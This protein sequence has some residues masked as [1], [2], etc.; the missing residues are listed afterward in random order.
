MKGKILLLLFFICSLFSGCERN[1][2]IIEIEEEVEI[3][4]PIVHRL[5]L[6]AAG[7]NLFHHTMIRPSPGGFNFT[8]YYAHIR[9][10]IEYADIAFINQET[11]L[12]GKEFGFSGFPLFNTPQEAGIALIEAGFN[13][14]SHAN[15]HVMDMGERAVF[16]TM[17]FWDRHPEVTVL[18]IHRSQEMRDKPVVIEKN[19]IRIGFLAYTFS[20]NGI[21]VPRNRPYL[22][23]MINTDV[24][25]RE[26]NALRPLCDFL[27]VSMHWGDEYR[28]T[29][30]AQQRQLADFLA[31]HN[32]DLILGHHPHVLQPMEFLPRADGGKM[33]CVFS[34]G[35]F[36]SAQIPNYTLLGGLL[37]LEVQ[38]KDGCVSI[39]KAGIIPVVTHYEQGST[40]F[41]VYPLFN[42][43]ETLLE[44]HRNK[45]RSDLTLE[46]FRTLA[47]DVLGDAFIDYNPFLGKYPIECY[48][49]YH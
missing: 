38:K 39:E 1:R 32:V 26:I 12:A 18:G 45:L 46:Y 19:G 34:L 10:L 5:T 44:T 4:E 42:Y 15:N 22:V 27:V 2:N 13:V 8:S 6:V 41:R 33:L 3:Q 23:S 20:T 29:P 25:A 47:I 11:L 21:P 9:L 49:G 37:Y 17:D 40:N 36:I 28:F 31:E 30:N 43:S 48:N 16:T 35:N 14:I 7:D 24:M